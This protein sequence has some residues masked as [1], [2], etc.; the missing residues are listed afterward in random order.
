VGLPDGDD[1][2]RSRRLR[3][4]G[5][6]SLFLLKQEK[7]TECGIACDSVLRLDPDN[8]KALYRK[9]LVLEQSSEL[10]E[11]AALLRRVD[12]R[13]ARAALRRV[14]EKRRAYREER[15]L[16]SAR[17]TV[18]R[19]A[20]GEA[21]PAAGSGGELSGRDGTRERDG[22]VARGGAALGAAVEA[23]RRD[24]KSRGSAEA[25]A[26]APARGGLLPTLAL[27]VFLVV[28]WPLLIAREIEAPAVGVLFCVCATISIVSLT[29]FLSSTQ[30][31]R[32]AARRVGK[33]HL[34]LYDARRARHPQPLAQAP[35]T[36]QP[37]PARFSCATCDA[38]A[39]AGCLRHCRLCSTC[40]FGQDHH[41]W[42]LGRCVD[43]FNRKFF[44]CFLAHACVCC[45]TCCFTAVESARRFRWEE[46][47]AAVAEGDA[48]SAVRAAA[49]AL[50]YLLGTLSAIGTTTLLGMQAVALW[51]H[52]PSHR[53]LS[54]LTE[55][56]PGGVVGT[57]FEDVFGTSIVDLLLLWAPVEPSKRR[58]ET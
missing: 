46:M 20:R 15:R 55:R 40:V 8:A 19:R 47:H 5:N 3:L 31:T 28:G 1:R 30:P 29:R 52:V 48:E 4:C 13:S 37:A 25:V 34:L 12:N 23:A 21:P 39:P 14:Q 57:R 53:W 18:R 22:S 6:L 16:M 50:V 11:A 24:A 43:N 44:L 9:A 35:E 27:A 26:G 38:Q 56:R 33:R 2:V 49:A 45:W 7:W 36:R 42:F 32:D 10:A 58:R 54:P 41:C 51:R 17:M